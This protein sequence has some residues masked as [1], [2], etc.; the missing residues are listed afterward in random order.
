MKFKYNNQTYT[1]TRKEI[2]ESLRAYF[3][4][5]G[6][7]LVFNKLTSTFSL[8]EEEYLLSESDEFNIDAV[9]RHMVINAI[10][11]ISSIP[12]DPIIN[13]NSCSL[14][15]YLLIDDEQ[16]ASQSPH[17]TI[18]QILEHCGVNVRLGFNTKIETGKLINNNYTLCLDNIPVAHQD[19]PFT[20][21][22]ILYRVVFFNRT[23]K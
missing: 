16:L 20:I 9:R 3:T 18:N 21:S 1:G 8:G 23:N 10:A 14:L 4:E 13:I 5:T 2:I 7:F 22:Q 6:T 15:N 12:F 11:K 19:R 17:F